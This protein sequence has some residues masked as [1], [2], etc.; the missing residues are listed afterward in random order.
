VAGEDGKYPMIN[1]GKGPDH[2]PVSFQVTLTGSFN[3]AWDA[4]NA[5]PV[6]II[7]EDGNVVNL[8]INPGSPAEMF[9]VPTTVNWSPERV[10][11]KNSYPAFVDW[12][13]DSSVKWYE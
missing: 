12:I 4:I 8:T 11:I 3:N 7:T 1:T 9:A 2:D 10:S 6:S 13:K 5:L